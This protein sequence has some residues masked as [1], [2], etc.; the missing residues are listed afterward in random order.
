MSIPSS[1]KNFNLFGDG[2]SWV[3]L[4]PSVTLPK[5]TR[6]TEEYRA[7]GMH[8]PIE[9]DLGHEKL[10][11]QFTAGGLMVDAL[12]SFGVVAH[13]ASQ[14]RFAGAYQDDSDG[15]VHALE[16]LTRGRLKEIELGDAKTGEKTE[17]KYSCALSYYKLT[18]DGLD[19][20]EI[21]VPGLVFRVGGIDTLAAIRRAIGL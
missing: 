7:G 14:W 16:I 21:D 17:H 20:M 8:G 19:L 5:L 11:L 1:L 2:A 15:S 3:G 13:N 10:E 9:I 18:V 4:V 6:K 12:R